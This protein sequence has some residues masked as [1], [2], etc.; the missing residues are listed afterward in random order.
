MDKLT[1]GLLWYVAFI[2]ST[3][4]HEASHA[5]AA[6]KLG[7]RTAYE[8]GQVT[9]DPLP[10]IKREP[11]GTVVV[12]IIS[13]LV[14]GWMIGWASA[15]YNYQWSLDY[16][17]RAAKMSLA[18]PLSNLLMILLS[19]IVIRLG[20]G[21][22][23]FFPPDKINFTHVVETNGEGILATSAL[24]LNIFFSLNL[25]LFIFNLLPIPPLD[26]S[27]MIPFFLEDK[28]ARRYLEFIRNPSFSFIGILV[29]WKVF[30]VIYDPIHLAIINL[31]Y[32]GIAQY[33]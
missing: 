21:Y 17:K 29:A 9:L 5:F 23:I 25:L 33:G 26:G 1:D 16:P 11:I 3:T 10:H 24:F 32:F 18:G 12:P 30:D 7:D 6:Y 15:P 20:I 28:N 13:F 2:F 31:V 19:A 8:G 27:G 14:G 22:E 4:I